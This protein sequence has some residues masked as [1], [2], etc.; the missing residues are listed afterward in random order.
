MKTGIKYLKKNLN[1]EKLLKSL[2]SKQD[3]ERGLD[4]IR[5]SVLDSS[6]LEDEEIPGLSD[7]FFTSREM[8]YNSLDKD[9]LLGDLLVKVSD[10]F[11]KIN[12][13]GKSL[14]NS[15]VNIICIFSKKN[16]KYYLIAS[17]YKD[18]DRYCVYVYYKSSN[19]KS[20]L[21]KMK[22]LIKE[23]SRDQY[24]NLDPFGYNWMSVT[25][26]SDS[27]AFLILF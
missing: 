8:L 22:T 5:E 12:S 1:L 2:D 9:S 20:I 6:G 7:P 21:V 3:F 23:A 27:M 19:K 15:D 24:L 13:W 14:D 4:Y 16:Q 17:E 11:K 18:V 26:V 25:S 10:N